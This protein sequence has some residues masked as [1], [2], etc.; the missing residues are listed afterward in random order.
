MSSEVHKTC[1]C[2]RPRRFVWVQRAVMFHVRA[3]PPFVL[4]GCHFW[5]LLTVRDFED[6]TAA[7]CF[8]LASSASVLVSP[9]LSKR[10]P[11]RLTSRSDLVCVCV[12]ASDAVRGNF[13]SQVS[14]L[15][16]L[17]SVLLLRSR[18][19]FQKG[20][21]SESMLNEHRENNTFY[22]GAFKAKQMRHDTALC[23]MILTCQL[24][25][26][27]WSDLHANGLRLLND[28]GGFGTITWGDMHSCFLF[29]VLC[30][31]ISLHVENETSVLTS[32]IFHTLCTVSDSNNNICFQLISRITAGGMRPLEMRTRWKRHTIGH[33][34]RFHLLTVC[35]SGAH[36]LRHLR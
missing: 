23:E 31:L 9:P 35:L 6:V 14:H 3:S 13:S 28:V 18:L 36:D 15:S 25:V 1:V 2:A 20:F 34:S 4:R 22:I 30:P 12:G 11:A 19:C 27:N 33:D 16:P 10:C 5:Q 24:L 21:C 29:F 26:G 32:Y 8:S 7:K 17:T